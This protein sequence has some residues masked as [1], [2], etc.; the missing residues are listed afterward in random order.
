MAKR[1]DDGKFLYQAGETEVDLSDF[2]KMPHDEQI[3]SMERTSQM[4]MDL[5]RRVE[6]LRIAIAH[7]QTDLAREQKTIVQV[8]ALVEAMGNFLAANSQKSKN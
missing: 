1:T 5:L 2:V 4:F 8:A 3:V 7:N 6:V